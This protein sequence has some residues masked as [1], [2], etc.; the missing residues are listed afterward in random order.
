MSVR[1]SNPG[2]STLPDSSDVL[3]IAQA[4]I[5]AMG[6]NDYRRTGAMKGI[7]RQPRE[8]DLCRTEREHSGR[9]DVSLTRPLDLEVQETK[10]QL[11][12][13]GGTML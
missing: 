4:A 11:W 8:R 5:M 13:G 7:V 12:S 1:G 2:P 6:A 10:E 9:A 3:P